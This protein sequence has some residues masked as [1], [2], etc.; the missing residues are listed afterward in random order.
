LRDCWRACAAALIA[1]AAYPDVFAAAGVHSGL[2]AGCARHVASAFA[3]MRSGTKAAPHKTALP[4]IVFHGQ[5][6]TT[7]HSGN[8]TAT[9]AQALPAMRNLRRRTRRDTVP[10][11]RNYSVTTCC[12]A[13]GRTMAEQ[14]QI[15]GAGD[16]W[17]GGQAGAS[18]TDPKGPDASRQIL[19]FF[20]QHA[21]S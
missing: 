2:P 4:T 18:Y 14:W 6:Y 16:A 3:A 17:T 12:H 15:D 8:G 19:R 20:S 11:G 5:V 10:G 1:A 13:D 9:L 21:L 7:V